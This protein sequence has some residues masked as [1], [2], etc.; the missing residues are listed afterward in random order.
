MFFGKWRVEKLLWEK[1]AGPEFVAMKFGERAVRPL[2]LLWLERYDYFESSWKIKKALD[3]IIGWENTS[4]AKAAL[5]KYISE[6]RRKFAGK[7]KPPDNFLLIV[8]YVLGKISR[9]PS[10][11]GSLNKILENSDSQKIQEECAAALLKFDM[12]ALNKEGI[13]ID[14]IRKIGTRQRIRQLWDEVNEIGK[15]IM[16]LSNTPG[17]NPWS[18][19][20]N[21]TAT[22]EECIKIDR[23][24]A[25]LLIEAVK[26]SSHGMIELNDLCDK[27]LHSLNQEEA[28]RQASLLDNLPEEQLL[29]M[30]KDRESSKRKDALIAI[31]KRGDLRLANKI[32]PMLDDQDEFVRVFAANALATLGDVSVVEKLNVAKATVQSDIQFH[33]DEAI[34]RLQRKA[35][36]TT[37]I[38]KQRKIGSNL[39]L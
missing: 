32:I 10:A 3:L 9:D 38:G 12:S 35:E 30:L 28:K 27:L 15:N 17:G 29:T 13:D 6:T 7:D 18:L 26:N 1:G 14:K 4:G 23:N 21:I 31:G 8:S 37:E 36:Q 19:I 25:R 24:E 2:L 5:S 39:E 33:F 22:L 20:P 11:I 34:A 16:R